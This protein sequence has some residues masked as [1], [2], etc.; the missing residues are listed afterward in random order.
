MDALETGIF[1]TCM[2]A[3]GLR[4]AEGILPMARFSKQIRTLFITFLLIC[5][6]RPLV[7]LELSSVA[8]DLSTDSMTQDMAAMGETARCNAVSTCIQK[9]LQSELDAHHV[10][11]EILDI[12]VHIEENG[13]IVI[14]EVWITGSTLTGTVYLREWLE[15]GVKITPRKEALE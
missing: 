10:E 6:L 3:M 8:P 4:L 14:D 2:A 9:S 7:G 15:E 11:C 5:L 1:C 13:G 12:A